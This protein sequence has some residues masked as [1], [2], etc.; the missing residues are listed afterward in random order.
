MDEEMG[1]EKILIDTTILIDYFRKKKKEKTAL[2]EISKN[3]DLIISVITEFEWLIGFK[4]KDYDFGRGLLENITILNLDSKIIATAVEIYKKLKSI[5]KLIAVPDIF[6]AAT[7]VLNNL[8]IATFN[9]NHFK[10]VPGLK[11]YGHLE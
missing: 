1:S 3:R 5:N 8:Q 7:A 4:E 2:I 10:R 6:I 9:K 11:I